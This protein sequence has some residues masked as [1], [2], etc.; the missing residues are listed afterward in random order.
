MLA[1]CL[2][3][4]VLKWK[5]IVRLPFDKANESAGIPFTVK[6]LASRVA[7]ST[8]P[9]TSTWKITGGGGPGI[10]LSQG[11]LVITEQGAA[12]GVGLGVGVPGWCGRRRRLR[13]VSGAG[14]ATGL[15]APDDHVTATPDCSVVF[16]SRGRRVDAGGRPTIQRRVVSP[17]G[18]R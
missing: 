8:A 5:L 11:P 13:T 3:G 1:P 10:N 14:I 15:T 2:A 6:S 17:A 9:V 16:S 7:G 18:G 4:D 12:L